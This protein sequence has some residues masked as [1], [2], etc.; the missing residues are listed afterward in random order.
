MRTGTVTRI[1]CSNDG[2][3]RYKTPA[4]FFSTLANNGDNISITV[5]S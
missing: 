5:A 1:Y 4:N 3:I 2:Y